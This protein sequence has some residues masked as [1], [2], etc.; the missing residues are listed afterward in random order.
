MRQSNV[1]RALSGFFLAIALIVGGG[2][3]T[4]Q[5][6]IAKFTELPPRPTFP[7][8]KPSPSP[9]KP[10][11]KPATSQPKASPVVAVSPSPTPSATPSAKPEGDRARITLGEGLNVRESASVESSRVGGVDYNEVVTILETSPDQEWQK[12][13]L[14][15]SGLEGWIK[16]GYT[17]PVSNSAANSTPESEF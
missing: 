5:F 16:S 12:V 9:T 6:V 4:T 3:L 13:R 1:V 14:E 11:A 15:K 8:D 7:N 2:Y 17:Q 10:A